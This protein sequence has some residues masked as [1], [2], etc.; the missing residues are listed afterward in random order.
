MKI[1]LY[2]AALAFVPSAFAQASKSPFDLQK[3][4]EILSK[5]PSNLQGMDAVNSAYCLGLLDGAIG[6]HHMDKAIA[7]GIPKFCPPSKISTY[8][9][10]ANVANLLKNKKLAALGEQVRGGPALLALSIA[11]PCP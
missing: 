10:A 8:E 3:G 7:P 4:C 1:I 6:A 11:Y 9:A 2:L 5:A